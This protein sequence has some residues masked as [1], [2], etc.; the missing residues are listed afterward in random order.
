MVAGMWPNGSNKTL[1]SACVGL[2]NIVVVLTE[3]TC[4]ELLLVGAYTKAKPPA[5]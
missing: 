3:S 1:L 2:E 5:V 4:A